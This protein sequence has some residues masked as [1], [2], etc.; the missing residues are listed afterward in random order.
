MSIE[1]VMPANHLYR[2]LISTSPISSPPD[3]RSLSACVI[4]ICP[5]IPPSPSSLLG[6]SMPPFLFALTLK[7][8]ASLPWVPPLSF[9]SSGSLWSCLYWF[10]CL[11]WSLLPSLSF[12]LSESLFLFWFWSLSL[13]LC[14]YKHM[15]FPSGS[16][17]KDSACKAGDPGSIPGLGRSPGERNGNPLQY[18][19]LE[20]SMD[21]GAWLQSMGSQRV[22]HDWATNT[23]THTH[24]PL[25]DSSLSP[26]PPAPLSFTQPFKLQFLFLFLSLPCLFLWFLLSFSLVPPPI[27]SPYLDTFLDLYFWLSLFL[28]L[29]E[30]SPLCPFQ[31]VCVWI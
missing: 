1:S 26:T 2:S 27:L 5:S 4:S 8:P 25:C 3:P 9:F 16:D 23:H 11:S 12:S 29:S 22:R 6:I 18:S 28:P 21:R 20:N 19:C 7:A 15:G 30:F 31:G 24:L 17:G 13:S 10:F 14:V